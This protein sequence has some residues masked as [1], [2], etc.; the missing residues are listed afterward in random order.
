MKTENHK[1]R[2]MVRYDVF[3]IITLPNRH[4]VQDRALLN[5]LILSRRLSNPH[6]T[7]TNILHQPDTTDNPQET[8][9]YC[10]VFPGRA[11]WDG[12]TGVNVA[13]SETGLQ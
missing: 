6:P 5:A 11:D 10:L 9:R 3:T 4:Q 12:L 13:K 8:K 1:T 7:P 2:M